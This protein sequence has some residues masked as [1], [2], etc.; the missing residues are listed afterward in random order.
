MA[1]Y[2]NGFSL[3]VRLLLL[4]TAMELEGEDDR[5][6]PTMSINGAPEEAPPPP[7][8]QLFTEQL[9][10]FRRY[11][12]AEFHFRPVQV[13]TEAKL[14]IGGE[15]LDL[16]VEEFHDFIRLSGEGLIATPHAAHG[17]I[18]TIVTKSG[19]H[20]F[21]DLV[22]KDLSWSDPFFA[23]TARVQQVVASR[24]GSL[25]VL[26]IGSRCRDATKSSWSDLRNLARSYVGIDIV[27]GPN[28]DFVGDAH[29]LAGVVS[30]RKFDF[31]YTQW[32]FEHL[33]MPWVVISEI[34]RVLHVGG[35]A[36]ILTNQSIGMHDRPWDFWRFSDHTW[37]VLFNDQTG[38]EI[39]ASALGEPVNLTP[40]RYHEAFI[41]HEAG[42]GF[43]ASA[44]WV[45][46]TLDRTPTW[47]VEPEPILSSLARPYPLQITD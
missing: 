31:V 13:V 30:Y 32:V 16:R 39:L 25:D 20:A 22:H 28:V 27:A 47:A 36:F 35:E 40:R 21:H 34:N 29:H 12:D 2:E 11:V 26:E 24:S 5:R 44:V 7:V 6:K 10:C 33:A 3:I 9:I 46:K 15:V 45:R 18:V 37:P 4:A 43:Q 42:V 23:L 38:F 17:A 1:S 41:G 19:S 14:K 8:P